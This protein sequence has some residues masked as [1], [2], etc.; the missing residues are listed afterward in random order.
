M[1]ANL[2]S[3][4]GLPNLGLKTDYG[5]WCGILLMIQLRAEYL[6]VGI[7]ATTAGM[8]RTMYVTRTVLKEYVELLNSH[9]VLVRNI[10][11]LLYRN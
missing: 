2:I 3:L 1:P 5:G 11:F 6:P 9:L 7:G 10:G 8:K 4:K